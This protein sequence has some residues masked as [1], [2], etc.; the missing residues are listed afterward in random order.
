M[1]CRGRAPC[2]AR[3]V[4]RQADILTIAFKQRLGLPVGVTVD[5]RPGRAQA[6]DFLTNCR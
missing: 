6:I 3:A 5:F 1:T 2:A 4:L